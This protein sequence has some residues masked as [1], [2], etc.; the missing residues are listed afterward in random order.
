M[1]LFFNVF[2]LIGVFIVFFFLCF[3]LYQIIWENDLFPSASFIILSLF[4]FGPFIG[5]LLSRQSSKFIYAS[6]SLL[7][8]VNAFFLFYSY[9]K[10]DFL[11]ASLEIQLFVATLI[12]LLGL[13][14]FLSQFPS[15]FIKIVQFFILGNIAF[16]A[17]FQ[18]A[19]TD[20]QFF[21]NLSL[22]YSSLIFT[23]AFLICSFHYLRKKEINKGMYQIHK[24][25]EA[26]NL[27]A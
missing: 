22:I 18:L 24:D 12:M 14:F 9:F 10:F 17:Y 15:F 13:F 20:N 6:M 26:N 11:E 5:V 27:T 8:F 7:N 21:Y 3:G 23:L 4:S 19:D 2:N 25:E 1:R 16:N